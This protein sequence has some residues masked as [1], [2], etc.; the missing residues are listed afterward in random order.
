MPRPKFA[1][2]FTSGCRSTKPKRSEKDQAAFPGFDDAL[3]ADLRT[4][5]EMF[6]DEVVWSEV[7]DYRQLVLADY[8]L[9]QR[10]AGEV[11]WPRSA[12]RW[13]HFTRS[14]SIP[15]SVRGVVTHPYLLAALA[16]HKS[17]SPIHRGVFVTRKL[18]GRTLNPPP[19]AI[20]FMDGDFDPH[21]TMREKV[22]ELTKSQNCQSCHSVINP[23]GFSLENFDA[24][25][26]FRTVEQTGTRSA[27]RRRRRSSPRS[28]GELIR[29]CR[30]ARR[31]RAC[32]GEPRGPPRV[33]RAAL[34]PRR[35]AA[36]RRRTAR[37]PRDRLTKS[38]AE[39]SYNIRK[40]LVEIVR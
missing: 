5:L 4:S 36:R 19:A 16:Y 39:S 14:P 22:S 6:I 33:C 30:R 37:K 1:S 21:M 25:G 2:S 13:R 29:A 10:A 23:L 7:S 17:S 34:P 32:G 3:V 18:L 31:G 12:G 20:Q 8:L 28:T 27:D 26:R 24:V 35:Q 9:A 15:S 40:L 11:L 38:F